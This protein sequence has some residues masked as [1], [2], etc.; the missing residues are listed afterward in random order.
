[1]SGSTRWPVSGVVSS[2]LGFTDPLLVSE[3]KPM[4]GEPSVVSLAWIVSEPTP[5]YGRISGVDA[6]PG[7]RCPPRRRHGALGSVVQPVPGKLE[8]L[9]DLAC[10]RPYRVG[11][12][13]PSV[14]ILGCGTGVVH[15]AHDRTAHQEPLGTAPARRESFIQRRQ[16]RG[17]RGAVEERH[18]RSV[19]AGAR[20][21]PAGDPGGADDNGVVDRRLATRSARRNRCTCTRFSTTKGSEWTSRS[22]RP[23]ERR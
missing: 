13:E 3:G 17:H 7:L 19:T 16:S 18:A 15:E 9:R 6:W 5:P 20:R 12:R 11:I 14:D 10:C 23:R 2:A 8:L 4:A 22:S 1:M 21:L